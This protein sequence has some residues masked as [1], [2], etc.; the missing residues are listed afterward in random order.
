MDDLSTKEDNVVSKI[1]NDVLTVS[2][3]CSLEFNNEKWKKLVDVTKMVD[4]LIELG[5]E[6]YSSSY[7]SN[8]PAYLTPS[9]QRK[10]WALTYKH[11]KI[12]VKNYE[13]KNF[14]LES[15]STSSITQEYEIISIPRGAFR[16]YDHWNLL[17]KFR[18]TDVTAI[19]SVLLQRGWIF[20]T[21]SEG[22]IPFW[23]K[24][25]LGTFILFPPDRGDGRSEDWIW[26]RASTWMELKSSWGSKSTPLDILDVGIGISARAIKTYRDIIKNPT[27]YQ[28]DEKN[29]ENDNLFNVNYKIISNSWMN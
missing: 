15:T 19:C 9:D 8:R 28:F 21:H 1:S 11:Y 22:K 14:D 26:V 23:D 17:S 29:K 20:T 25:D 24:N 10:E 12:M 27:L 3:L 16:D 7:T 13:A 18:F 4:Q 5:W 6:Y 2:R